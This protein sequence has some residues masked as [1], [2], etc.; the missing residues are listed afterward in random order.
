MHSVDPQVGCHSID[1]TLY[2]VLY[3]RAFNVYINFPI[4]LLMVYVCTYVCVYMQIARVNVLLGDEVEQLSSVTE[5]AKMRLALLVQWWI[6]YRGNHDDLCL[7]LE[8]ASSRLQRL[9]A[10][11]ESTHP[12]RVSPTELLVDIQARTIPCMVEH[13]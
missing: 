1:Y 3:V 8:G 10:R 2:I 5:K 6:E 9:V 13:F 11:A 4:C 12:P 7:W